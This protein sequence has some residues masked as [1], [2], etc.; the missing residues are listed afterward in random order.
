[1]ADFE[2]GT[3]PP[4]SMAGLPE[5]S[6]PEGSLPSSI[7]HS[8]VS[9]SEEKFLAKIAPAFEPLPTPPDVGPARRLSSR[10]LAQGHLWNVSDVVCG[11][12]PRDQPFEEQHSD[13]CVAI[14][15]AGSFQYRSSAGRELMTCGSLL[16]GN[17]GQYFECAHEHAVG[18]RCISFAYSQPYFEELAAE[19]GLRNR[20][21]QFFSL[22]VP[23]AREVSAVIS[24]ACAALAAREVQAD[25][26]GLSVELA[27]RALDFAG[28]QPSPGSSSAAEAR[29]TRI[30]RMIE[31][32]PDWNQGLAALARE[33]KL[34]RFHFLRIF[35]QLTRLTP[36]QYIRRARLRRAA[37]RLLLERAKVLDIAL[38]CGFGDVSNFN[39]V[40]RAEFGVSPRSYRKTAGYKTSRT[41][42]A[43][44]R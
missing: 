19:A 9:F 37:T 43:A 7:F 40:F 21:A 41:F 8:V 32:H 30:I 2:A 13:V 14:V 31:G 38:D 18:D 33:A 23:P 34:S 26:E 24:R 39:H 22:R 44:S 12:G 42:P 3:P 36:H 17:A 10:R 27:A 6:L 1:M 16:L 20:D 5:G 11:A 25:W 15:V 28:S 29:V 4:E 35:Q